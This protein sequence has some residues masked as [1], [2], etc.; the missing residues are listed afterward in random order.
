MKN[1]GSYVQKQ[2]G[3]TLIELLIAISIIGILASVILVSLSNARQRS[4]DASV[5]SSMT[6]ADK[7]AMVCSSSLLNINN[8]TLLGAVCAG[9]DSYANIAANSSGWVYGDYV[10]SP[11]C[12]QN[13]NASTGSFTICAKY[14]TTKGIKCTQNGCTKVGF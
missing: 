5:F 12:T 6:S 3:F 13:L 10:L 14:G 2:G 8:P 9:M 7:V 11:G 4:K 1:K